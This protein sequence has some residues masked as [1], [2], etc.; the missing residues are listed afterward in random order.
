MKWM[1][2]VLALVMGVASSSAQAQVNA[3]SDRWSPAVREVL[4]AKPM[5]ADLE[6]PV[7]LELVR[8]WN[9]A[10]AKAFEGLV[11]KDGRV[12]ATVFRRV[13]DAGAGYL[14]FT[15]RGESASRGRVPEYEGT[16]ARM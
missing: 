16:S 2:A 10:V 1:F 9:A 8:T 13:D 12:S 15:A 6:R 14:L 4:L 11:G 5:S 7:H 3:P